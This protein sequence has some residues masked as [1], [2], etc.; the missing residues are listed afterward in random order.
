MKTY[1]QAIDLVNDPKVIKKYDEYHQNVWPE[2]LEAI[3]NHGNSYTCLLNTRPNR[4]MRPLW[5]KHNF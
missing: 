5:F 1:A 3:K 4:H 2:D